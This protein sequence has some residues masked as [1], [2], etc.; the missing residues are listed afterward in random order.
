MRPWTRWLALAVGMA[1][2]V[3]LFLLL[4]PGGGD[5]VPTTPS[6]PSS[7][8][9]TGGRTTIRASVAGDTVEAPERPVAHLGDDVVIVVSADVTDEVHVH[10]YDVTAEVG[11]GEPG[12]IRFVA[13]VPGVFEVELEEEER[14]LF[15]L[16]VAP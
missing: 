5:G 13:D 1:A 14:V 12:T 3:V 9:G 7:S 16:E 15:Q 4:R 11:P 8:S 2:I 10:G 6:S